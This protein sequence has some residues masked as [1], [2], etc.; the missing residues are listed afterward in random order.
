MIKALKF[1][2]IKDKYDCNLGDLK[3]RIK[4]KLQLYNKG[5]ILNIIENKTTTI[6]KNS[7]KKGTWV[8]TNDISNYELCSTK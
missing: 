4:V 5:I 8:L 1:S 7:W 6:K 3:S 2:N